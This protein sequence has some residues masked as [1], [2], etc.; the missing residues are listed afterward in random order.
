MALSSERGVVEPLDIDNYGVWKTRMEAYLVSKGLAG[1]LTTDPPED[2]A[3]RAAWDEVDG[4]A[5][6][7]II[8]S[9][10]DHH[11]ATLVQSE[12]TK[13]AWQAL[14]SMFQA[15]TNARRLQLRREMNDLRKEGGEP[16][17]KYINRALTDQVDRAD[18]HR[19]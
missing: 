2:A 13:Q 14:E 12:S 15:K 5:K 16:L 17:T 7:L 11:L 19:A 4:K 1:P 10:K 3:A 8:M 18:H 9:V 6:A